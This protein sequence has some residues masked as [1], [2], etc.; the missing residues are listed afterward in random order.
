MYARQRHPLGEGALT[1][2][3]GKFAAGV[4]AIVGLLAAAPVAQADYYISKS[5]AESFTRS[6]VHDRYVVE[7]HTGVSCRPQGAKSARAGYV[8]HR[9]TCV[10]VDDVSWGAFLIAGSSRGHDWYFVKLL[11]GATPQ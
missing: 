6:E 11:K 4:A 7:G 9:W 2:M 5:R 3:K 1:Y 10:W 8:Y